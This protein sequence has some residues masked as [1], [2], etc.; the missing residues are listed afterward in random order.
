MGLLKSL[1]TRR[2]RRK[3][4]QT[5]PDIPRRAD[6]RK[7]FRN[8]RPKGGGRFGKCR[9][10][11]EGYDPRILKGPGQKGGVANETFLKLNL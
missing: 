2:R 4:Y 6:R 7:R 9:N 10:R 3:V 8:K 5:F 1:L 11:P